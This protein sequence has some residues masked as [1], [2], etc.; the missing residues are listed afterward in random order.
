[1]CEKLVSQTVTI[2]FFSIMIKLLCCG[3]SAVE[4]RS[5]LSSRRENLT[6]LLV[7]DRLLQIHDGVESS[8]HCSILC[9][10]E[11]PCVSFFYSPLSSACRLHSITL[12]KVS[13]IA[14]DNGSQYFV[15]QRGR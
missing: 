13:E 15:M 12:G 11:S 7:T 10:D 4:I 9:L 6:N 1:M 5:E 2:M 14:P 3:N 8:I